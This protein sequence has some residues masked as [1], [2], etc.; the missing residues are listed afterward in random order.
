VQSGDLLALAGQAE[1]IMLFVPTEDPRGEVVWQEKEEG[2]VYVKPYF[3]GDRF[4][5]VR[6][7][8]FNVTIRYR[9]TG[10]LMG[11]LNLPDLL[12]HDE[13]PMLETGPRTLPVAHDGNLLIVT[14]GWYYIA[15]D[16]EKPKI[17]W[18]RLIDEND[19]TQ[20]PPMRFVLQGDYFAVVKRNYDVKAIFML[21]SRTGE[22]LWRTDPKDAGSPQPLSSMFIQGGKLYGIRPHPGQGFYFAAMDCATGKELFRQVEQTGYGGKPDAVIRPELYGQTA[23]VLVR[24]RQDFEVKAFDA[25]N[26]KLIHTLKVKATGDFG[27]HG[28]A[29]ATVQNG[30]LALLGKNDLVLAMPR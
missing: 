21:S 5:S 7:M 4:V 30:G 1:T 24:D 27:E 28:R 16:I 29:S 15:I 23:V 25:T 19:I 12:L 20:L 10:R 26:G 13:H 2:D 9:S 8:P 14:D 18:K 3:H 11:R 6:K 22:V 17:V